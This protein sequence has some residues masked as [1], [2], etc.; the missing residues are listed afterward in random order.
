[1][2][3]L[4]RTEL[5]LSVNAASCVSL[6]HSRVYYLIFTKTHWELKR[7]RYVRKFNATRWN[8]V[9]MLIALS[10]IAYV[11]NVANIYFP[12]TLVDP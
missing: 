2:L 8:N 7:L 3:R 4:M 5:P 10:I 1:M 9:M 12:P 6:L 11:T